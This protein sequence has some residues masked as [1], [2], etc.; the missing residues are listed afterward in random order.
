MRRG[1]DRFFLDEIAEHIALDKY[2][3]AQELIRQEASGVAETIALP[4]S[5]R[6][7]MSFFLQRGKIETLHSLRDA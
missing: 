4:L 3:A 6:W 7:T 5:H 2:G 1:K